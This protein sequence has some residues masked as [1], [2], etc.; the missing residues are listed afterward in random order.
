MKNSI[1]LFGI[2][3]TM[4]SC[5]NPSTTTDDVNE[6]NTIAVIRIDTQFPATIKE[7]SAQ[8]T[9]IYMGLKDQLVESNFEGAQAEAVT[10]IK[11]V[12][13]WKMDV[14]DASQKTILSSKLEALRASIGVF[15]TAMDIKGQRKVFKEITAQY[16]GLVKESGMNSTKLYKQFCPMA[17]DGEGA[18]W[19]SKDSTIRN[20]YFG[21]E[22]LECGEVTTSYLFK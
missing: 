10:F 6:S 16:E 5:S 8:L 9:T 22:M 2:A 12:D 20:P 13:A 11:A 18:Y 1:F 17:F 19:L 3:S 7:E 21:D 4:L 15:G 14:L